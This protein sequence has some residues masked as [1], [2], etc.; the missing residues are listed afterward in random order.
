MALANSFV[1]RMRSPGRAL[2]FVGRLALSLAALPVTAVLLL[3]S[4]YWPRHA[5]GHLDVPPALAAGRS[6]SCG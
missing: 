1:R 6:S 5:A 3:L 2:P 4:I